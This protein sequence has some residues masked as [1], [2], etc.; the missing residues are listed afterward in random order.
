M[1]DRQVSAIDGTGCVSQCHTFPYPAFPPKCPE[2][3]VRRTVVARLP[4]SPLSCLR[5]KKFGGRTSVPQRN[6]FP[7]PAVVL[8]SSSDEQAVPQKAPLPLS[9]LSPKPPMIF[10]L[11]ET[12]ICHAE[13]GRQTAHGCDL[14]VPHDPA[15]CPGPAVDDSVGILFMVRTDFL[16]MTGWKA[17]WTAPAALAND[18][19]RFSY[20]D[21]SLIPHAHGLPTA[22]ST[23]SGDN[24]LPVTCLFFQRCDV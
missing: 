17:L 1:Q 5:G 22:L 7:Y 11:T 20:P 9:C 12:G 15:G 14:A 23:K 16:W 4:Y 24:S 8:K 6:T 13:F 18:Q 3:F 19:D 21:Q 2:K 10:C